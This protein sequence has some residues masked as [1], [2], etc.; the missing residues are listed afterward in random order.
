[1]ATTRYLSFI[2]AGINHLVAGRRRI[3]LKGRFSLTTKYT[4]ETRRTQSKSI[5]IKFFVPFVYPD[6]YRDLSAL[7]G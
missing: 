4:K 3:V 1:M 7:C 5:V 6:S 2:F